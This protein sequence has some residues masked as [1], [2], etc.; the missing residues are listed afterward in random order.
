MLTGVLLVAVVVAVAGV[1][2]VSVTPSPQAPKFTEFY[3]LGPNGTAGEHPTN[4][5]T[6]ETGVLTV[7]IT[8]QE[9]TDLT[10]TVLA[11]LNGRVVAERTTSVAAGET[12]EERLRFT[13]ETTGTVPFRLELYRLADPARDA[14]PYRRLVVMITVTSPGENETVGNESMMTTAPVDVERRF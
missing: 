10:Y 5:T 7:G 8:N 2:Y 1:A 11:R 3:V 6:G 4:L 9:R 14:E 12:W 13:P